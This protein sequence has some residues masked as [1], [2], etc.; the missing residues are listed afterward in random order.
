L[1]MCPVLKSCLYNAVMLL[2]SVIGEFLIALREAFEAALIIAI[3]YSYVRK[4]G[5]HIYA[6]YLWYGSFLAMLSG[7]FAGIYVW[8]LYGSLSRSTQLL[9]EFASAWTATTVLSSVIYWMTTKAPYLKQDI[10]QRVA[11]Y[12]SKG[13]TVGLGVFAFIAVFREAVEMALFLTPFIIITPLFSFIGVTMGILAALVLAY[14][15]FAIGVRLNIRRFFYM[16]AVLLILIAGG[17]AGYGA[18]EFVEYAEESGIELGWLS[19]IAYSLPIQ[20]SDP[21]HHKGIIGSIFAVMVGYTV[22]A[23][24][25]RVILHVSYLLVALPAIIYKYRSVK[26]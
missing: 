15:I 16:T 19:E 6:K 25:L 23:E 24:W 14:V 7:L 21:L 4:V 18:H 5:G 26:S 9:F 11:T 8:I 10:E 2:R 3:A 1:A 12:M 20:Q 17:L 13:E 22:K